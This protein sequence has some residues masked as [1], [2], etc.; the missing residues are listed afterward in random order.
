[1]KIINLI[2]VLLLAV[3]CASNPHH[4]SEEAKAMEVLSSKPK[5]NECEI[6]AKV[7]GF[8]DQGS[9]RMAKNMAQNKAADEGADSIY[10]DESVSNGSKREVMATGYKCN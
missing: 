1:M 7:K 4:L 6:L 3:G 5:D 10:F 9:E 8:H 2:L